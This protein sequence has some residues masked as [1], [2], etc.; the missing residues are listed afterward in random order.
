MLLS[1]F[2]RKTTSKTLYFYS[3]LLIFKPFPTT[4]CNY[5]NICAPK[6]QEFC[7]GKVW[8]ICIHSK[9]IMLICRT[10]NFAKNMCTK[11]IADSC[12][13]RTT[14][15]LTGAGV[16]YGSTAWLHWRLRRGHAFWKKLGKNFWYVKSTFK[17]HR[18]DV[19]PNLCKHKFVAFHCRGG[20]H[21]LF[22]QKMKQKMLSR[23][24]TVLLIITPYADA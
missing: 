22:A 16:I 12:A 3:F 6:L 1:W 15:L 7:R 23:A 19:S 11:H 14:V 18:F 10:R 9:N 24:P 21:F 13:H 2:Y 20:L 4:C 5:Y 8:I 17:E